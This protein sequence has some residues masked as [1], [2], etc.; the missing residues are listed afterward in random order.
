MCKTTGRNHGRGFRAFMWCW[1]TPVFIIDPV[2]RRKTYAVAG[3]RNM[4]RVDICKAAHVDA[5]LYRKRRRI[6]SV[7][8]HTGNYVVR[9]K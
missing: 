3:A 6:R 9:R 1:T 2:T 5:E 4:M 8:R 7:S